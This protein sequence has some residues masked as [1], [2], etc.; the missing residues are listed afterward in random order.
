MQAVHEAACIKWPQLG[1]FLTSKYKCGKVIIM[2]I[3]E[4]FM[5]EQ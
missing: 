4:E 5:T 2:L 1:I 3:A